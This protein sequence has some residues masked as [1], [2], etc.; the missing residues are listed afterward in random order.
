MALLTAFAHASNGAGAAKATPAR[1]DNG[2]IDLRDHDFER[3]PVLSLEGLWTGCARRLVEQREYAAGQ[4]PACDRA[5]P[6]PGNWRDRMLADETSG[7]SEE[8]TGDGRH[9][10]TRH[11]RVLLPATDEPLALRLVG[12]FPANRVWINGRLAAQTGRIATPTGDEVGDLALQILPLPTGAGS[13][14]VV[15]QASNFSQIPPG[16]M[17]AEVGRADAIGAQQTRSWAL[18]MVAV[19]VLL[20]TG[21]YH[22]ALYSFRRNE[23]GPLHLGLSCLLWAGNLL[24]MGTSEWAIRIFIPDAPGVLLF[25]IW[26]F[27][28]FLASAFSYQFYRALYP[29]EFPRWIARALWGVSLGC[30]L[31]AL[32]APLRTL[33][34]ILPA[35]YL[36]TVVRLTFS[37]WALALAA[38]RRRP[39]AA[40]ILCGYLLMLMLTISDLLNWTGTLHTSLTV[41]LGMIA[42]MFAQALALA[43]RFSTLHTA[44]ERLSTALESKNRVLGGEIAERIRLQHEIVSVSEEERRL[45]SRELHDGLCQQL[46]AARLQ[47]AG[48]ATLCPQEAAS[49]NELARLS[50]LLD[51]SVDHAY[52]LAHGLWPMDSQSDDAIAALSTLVQRQREASAICIDFKPIKACTQCAASHTAQLYGIAREAIANAVK[53]AAAS[54]ITVTL[55]CS[56]VRATTLLID[57]DGHP[58]RPAKASHG[59]LGM[60]IMIYRAQMSGGEIAVETPPIGG[61]RVRC[62]VPCPHGK[63]LLSPQ[64]A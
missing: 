37:A 18:A 6:M 48:L 4:R 63:S 29:Q 11:L 19:G 26:P 38:R 35:Y 46:T 60:R 20:L 64:D 44:V 10:A 39:G 50:I 1:V 25:R 16:A 23:A 8:I 62:T 12:F 52:D 36:I 21:F 24:C 33:A 57:D 51:E 31:I 43:L 22:L 2:L 56:D 42:N 55:D 17:H 30:A 41:H 45:M 34:A 54:R 58:Q 61:T 15:I 9:F 7:D 47:C 40:I 53:H 32:A 14:E 3:W 5:L 13:V 49:A 59:G 28:L 27:C